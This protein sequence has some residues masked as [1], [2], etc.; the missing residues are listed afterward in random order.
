MT[1][2]PAT[3][4]LPPPPSSVGC[5]PL[6]AVHVHVQVQVSGATQT[7]CN[8]SGSVALTLPPSQ[9]TRLRLSLADHTGA[10]AALGLACPGGGSSCCEARQ[11]ARDSMYLST[12]PAAPATSW[13]LGPV[14][15]I[16]LAL[17]CTGAATL[18]WGAT[19]VVTIALAGA[20]TSSAS[21]FLGGTTSWVPARPNYIQDLRAAS[22]AA[23]NTYSV[24]VTPTS[25]RWG[26]G[27]AAPTAFSWSTTV[28]VGSLALDTVH[29]FTLTAA[30]HPFHLHVYP[31]PIIS[32]CG[33][34]YTEGEFYD[35][36]E[37]TAAGTCVVRFRTINI[38]GRGVMHCHI[39]GNF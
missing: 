23:A 1:H 20:S 8:G 17:R 3:H 13:A 28:G 29:Q 34:G 24:G 10:Q 5:C 38:G 15:R 37:P 27:T 11:V 6:A 2:P 36:V 7:R 39:L 33:A 26:V 35:T 4:C 18:S 14:A 31:M 12:V 19:S 21:P 22:V 9:W 25:I 16:D 30:N 32:G